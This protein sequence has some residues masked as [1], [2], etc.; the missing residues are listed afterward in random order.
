MYQSQNSDLYTSSIPYYRDDITWCVS[1]AKKKPEWLY[2]FLVFDDFTTLVS[3]L[4]LYT[5]YLATFYIYSGADGTNLNIHVIS[6]YC[7]Q[8]L[9]SF[10]ADYKPAAS[11]WSKFYTLC[12][13]FMC[14][15][16][17]NY[18]L[19][20]YTTIIVFPLYD[21]QVNTITDIID[22]EFQLAG[23]GST[24]NELRLYG[25]VS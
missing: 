9:L 21:K 2:I 23:A 16:I 14:F 19:A 10:S 18:Y 24:L 6:A 15:I 25:E 7:F 8:F 17:C 13:V 12:G 3:L 22:N 1:S 4:F 11:S 20:V 5:V